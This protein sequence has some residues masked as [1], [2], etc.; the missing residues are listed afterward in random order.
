MKES[1]A[2]PNSFYNRIIFNL[3]NFWG[4][5]HYNTVCLRTNLLNIFQIFN[6]Y[7][8]LSL[9]V[10]LNIILSTAYT[11]RVFNSPVVMIVTF[12]THIIYFPPQ[13]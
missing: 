10:R 7:A 12:S 2:I 6:N 8:G 5:V 4:A 9:I 1:G 13:N 3:S 11:T